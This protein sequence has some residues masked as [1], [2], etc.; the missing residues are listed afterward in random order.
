MR[1]PQGGVACDGTR[2]VQNLSNPICRHVQ[3]TCKFSGAHI[4]RFKFFR[5]VFTRMNCSDR[6]VVMLHGDSR[7]SLRSRVL[8][9]RQT[10]YLPLT[11]FHRNA[12]SSV[13]SLIAC[14]TETPALWPLTV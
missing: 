1:E 10:A 4:E 6:H 14:A 8:A 12:N 2:P 5:Q 9:L 3:L 11:S 7:R 13:V